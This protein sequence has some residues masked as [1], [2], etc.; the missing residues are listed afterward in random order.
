MS[1]LY[2]YVKT[3]WP[4]TFNVLPMSDLTT[5]CIRHLENAHS[6]N[7]ANLPNVNTFHH[8]DHVCSYHHQ[9]PQKSLSIENMSSSRRQY[10]FSKILIFAWKLLSLA[11]LSV[12]LEVKGSFRSFLENVSQ[13]AKSKYHNLLILSSRNGYATN[14]TVVLHNCFSSRQP[15]LSAQQECSCVL[16]VIAERELYAQ[17]SRFNTIYLLLVLLRTFLRE[18]GNFFTETKALRH[19]CSIWCHCLASCPG[20]SCWKNLG[21]SSDRQTTSWEPLL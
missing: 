3:H 2:S 6:L 20:T 13:I 14:N 11:T 17:G 19:D 18:V 12:S 16:P 21:I 8:T 10:K 1:F 9:S 4:Y 5:S 7:Y 15:H